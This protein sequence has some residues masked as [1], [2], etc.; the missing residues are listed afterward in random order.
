M[1]EP[2]T[3]TATSPFN[4][5]KGSS[6]IGGSDNEKHKKKK[7][8]KACGMIKNDAPHWDLYM[9]P[10]KIQVANFASKNINKM[11]KWNDK[12]CACPQWFLQK[13]CFSNCKHKD[14]HVKANKTQ[15][16]IWPA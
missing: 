5:K 10:N 2:K 4:G 12:C 6:H 14:S 3:T 9:L 16:I 7:P 13:Y 15:K 1:K 8:D 11:P